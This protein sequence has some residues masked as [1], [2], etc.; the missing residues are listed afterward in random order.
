M[1]YE[2]KKVR[3]IKLSIFV[4][5]FTLTCCTVMYSL[6]IPEA[7]FSLQQK[8]LLPEITESIKQEC[9]SEEA[10]TDIINENQQKTE[11]KSVDDN[12]EPE[13][14]LNDK[15]EDS[16]EASN[17]IS[18]TYESTAA[19]SA[20]YEAAAMEAQSLLSF[21]EKLYLIGIARYLDSRD[22]SLI[23]KYIAEGATQ[24]ELDG[25][26]AQMGAK[27]PKDDYDKVYAIFL[28]YKR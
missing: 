28:K 16:S 20:K 24:K 26:W 19:S 8:E 11:D 23:K 15:K 4:I 12:E 22:F 7:T 21:K 6:K 14:M 10:S 3:Y 25:L 18:L 2:V 5:L 9:K 1:E 13:E 27:L 17:Y